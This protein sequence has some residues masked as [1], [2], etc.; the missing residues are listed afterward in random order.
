MF[1]HAGKREMLRNAY[2]M[3]HHLLFGKNGCEG[4]RVCNK[5]R[6]AINIHFVVGYRTAYTE[7]K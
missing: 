5:T 4:L 1:E 2:L 7:Q 6:F 3:K